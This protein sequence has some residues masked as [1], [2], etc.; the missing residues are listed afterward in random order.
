MAVTYES[1]H[2]TTGLNVSSL[3][4]ASITGGT[5]QTYVAFIYV[6]HADTITGISGGGLTW[7]LVGSQ[8][9]GRSQDK[10]YCYE[11][12]GSPSAFTLTVTF[13]DSTGAR[14]ITVLRYSGVDTSSPYEGA[15]GY[16]TNGING[17]GSGG[18]DSTALTLSFSGSGTADSE[19]VAFLGFR[20]VSYSG[21]L[22]SDYTERANPDVGSG[23]ERIN[24]FIL[25]RANSGGLSS[26][27]CNATASVAVDWCTYGL[28]LMPGATGHSDPL[29]G[30]A[31]ETDTAVALGAASK[32]KATGTATESDAAQA[33]PAATKTY[34]A[35]AA[36]TETDSAVALSSA[37]KTKAPGAAA[38]T[39]TA[40]ALPAAVKVAPALTAATE[41]DA[42]QALA[43][44]VKT[45]GISP[46][47]ET[48][49]AQVLPG[50]L[51][52]M[53]AAEETDTAVALPVA[54]KV[55]PALGTPLETDAA[56][57]LPTPVKT[58]AVTA[59][60]ET[61]EAQ[62]VGAASKVAPAVTPAA[63]T[64]TAVALPAVAFPLTAA[65]ETDTAVALPTAAKAKAISPATES[66]TAYPLTN[67][68]DTEAFATYT[69]EVYWD[70]PS[71][72]PFIIGTSELSSSDYLLGELGQVV[73][74]SG[75]ATDVSDD[76][77][78]F[79][80]RRGKSDPTANVQAGQATL[81]LFDLT[82]KYNP[83]NSSSS[84]Y[85]KITPGKQVRIR[86]AIG[87]TTYELFRGFIDDAEYDV[88]NYTLTLVAKDALQNLSEAK[89]TDVTE[90]K[91]QS[92][93]LLIDT[94]VAAAGVY[95]AAYRDIDATL[96]GSY[97]VPA[98]SFQ[99]AQSILGSIGD[100][101]VIDQG[102]VFVTGGGVVTFVKGSELASLTSSGILDDNCYRRSNPAVSRGNVVNAVK[103]TTNIDG[104][105]T[106]YT[107]QDYASIIA[108][109]LKAKEVT[110]T[111]FTE[112]TEAQIFA[113]AIVA[114]NKDAIAAN[115]N[116]EIRANYSRTVMAFVFGVELFEEVTL[117]DS[118]RLV[119]GIEHHVKNKTEHIVKW[120]LK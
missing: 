67:L 48:D 24:A 28:I 50:A 49:E 27:T 71:S 19:F 30:Q 111:Y 102:E 31:L 119:V 57:A 106:I 44:P 79:T 62:A 110:T 90:Y 52:V 32:S 74:Y 87:G 15:V 86:A 43:S 94:G 103:V 96:G 116:T 46:A 66:D 68:F 63:E 5:D 6:R 89:S 105:T 14:S 47:E 13:G 12:Q 1:V 84:L 42:A 7:N 60:T 92:I 115:W 81:N 58:Q 35:P 4:L 10:V 118:D 54:T 2:S 88:D 97:Q 120:I 72:N 112:A 99:T 117:R 11:A 23:G 69:I 21:S 56:V 41:T 37:T 33:L 73:E 65:T 109:G 78:S 80:I 34:S 26:D 45:L 40:V 101:L 8:P 3:A 75:T 83:E 82:H 76:C 51:V 53:H 100:L 104:V 61:D 64:D 25:N 38:E 98:F 20:T 93:G 16:N 17:S 36:A 70:G 22:D 77:E 95:D 18:T 9:G 59:A 55:G 85:G 29:G 108:N 114:R 107:A 113:D 39:D 91:G